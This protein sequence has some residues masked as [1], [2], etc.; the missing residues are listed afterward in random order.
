[1]LSL[2]GRSATTHK[3]LTKL[4]STNAARLW[5]SE[6]RIAR[7]ELLNSTSL[8]VHSGQYIQSGPASSKRARDASIYTHY[9]FHSTHFTTLISQHSFH[10]THFTTLISQHSFHNNVHQ[11]FWNHDYLYYLLASNR[12][13]HL[14]ISER[15]LLNLILASAR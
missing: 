13:S 8:T 11:L 7:P 1:M 6:S 10:N 12:A 9:S 3:P 14:L 4:T 15:R 5:H 2:P